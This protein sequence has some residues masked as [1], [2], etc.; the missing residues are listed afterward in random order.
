MQHLSAID[1][2][3][4]QLETAQTPTHLA[5]L[6]LLK[7]P[8]HYKGN[9]PEAFTRHI[10]RRLHLAPMLTRKLVTM[11]LDLASPVWVH[12]DDID[13][14][15]HVRRISL[16]SPGTR[17]QLMATVGRLHSIIMDRSR[18]L[19][20]IVLIEGLQG[21]GYAMV[22]K[23][24]HAGLDGQSGQRLVEALFDT[25]PEPRALAPAPLQSRAAPDSN[26]ALFAASLGNAAKQ[27]LRLLRNL[28]ATIRMVS[29]MFPKTRRPADKHQGHKA[30]TRGFSLGPPRLAFNTTVSNQRLFAAC[31]M[32][33][34][35]MKAV[36]H[37]T[38]CTLNDLIM[39]VSASA[40]RRYLLRHGSLPERPLVGAMPI[41]V[42]APGDTEMSNR[43]SGARC[44]LHTDIEDPLERLAA[45][46]AST[47]DIKRNLEATRKGMPTDF[48]T[49]GVPWLL[50]LV[51]ALQGK[52]R[53]ADVMPPFANLIISNVATSPVPL[54]IAGAQVM[55]YW[56]MLI[57]MHGLGLGLA[58]HSYAGSMEWGVVGCRHAVPDVDDFTR[59]LLAS[60]AEL[61]AAVAAS[62]ARKAKRPAR[63]Q[64][65][66]A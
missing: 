8:A 43:V 4:L 40:L 22:L 16:P 6:H 48:P 18:P 3:F 19:W 29:G 60:F 27:T 49:L 47:A 20:E 26:S 31:S 5:S 38:G 58:T 42:R 11:P 64:R 41:S 10:A 14:D 36:A 2:A 65:T 17:E 32:P 50:P 35:D 25:T 59:D 55:T 37:A 24:H 56:P 45:I 15:Y 33:I 1:A 23:V 44:D 53:L 61:Q 57:L 28:P 66:K 9:F 34:A 21:G 13:I 7:L 39:A 52:L 63:S 46:C 12:D 62:A 30:Q 51:V 54:Y